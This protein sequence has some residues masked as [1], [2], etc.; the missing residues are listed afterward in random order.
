MTNALMGSIPFLSTLAALA[1]PNPMIN[2]AVSGFLYFLYFP[3]MITYGRIVD[4]KR[5][6]LM[7][8]LQSLPIK[9]SFLYEVHQLSCIGVNKIMRFV[10]VLN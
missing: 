6:A 10:V 1:I 3:V 9:V 5:R 8:S 2:G 7:D 4:K